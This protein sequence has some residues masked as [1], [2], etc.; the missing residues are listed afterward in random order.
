MNPIAEEADLLLEALQ[1]ALTTSPPAGVSSAYM[2]GFFRRHRPRLLT[3]MARVLD[4]DD[5]EA[6]PAKP[7]QPNAPPDLWT[8]AQRTNANLRAMEILARKTPDQITAQDRAAL[9]LY[10]GWGGLSIEKVKARFPEGSETPEQ[11][12]L[13][14]EYYTPTAV[15]A[16]VARVVQPLLRGLQSRAGRVLALEP[17]AGIGRFVRA[18]SGPGFESVDWLTVEW[19]AL[20]ARML[21]TLR[22]DLD[23][24]QGPFERWVRERGA[25]VN[26]RLKLVIS[27]PPY[28]ARGASISEDP[29]RDYREK[30]AYAYFLRR[31]LDL[32]APRGLGVFLVPSGFLSG[33]AARNEKLRA[34]VLRRHHL[35]AAFRLPSELF[36]GVNLVTDLIFFRA[37][38]VSMDE[39]PAEDRYI[40]EGDYFNRHPANILGREVGK[41][42]GEDQPS[43]FYRYTIEGKFSKL[44][45]LVERPICAAC[46]ID[47][48]P[49]AEDE[50]P[51]PFLT[52]AGVLRQVRD[53]ADG[54]SD[55][56][57]L[58]VALGLRVDRY[59]T[60]LAT[61]SPEEAA[62]LWGELHHALTS[63][64][65]RYG[66]PW[67]DAV[68]VG[69]ARPPRSLTGAERFLAAF[70]KLGELIPGLQQR[71]AVTRRYNGRRDDVLA[72]AEWLFKSRRALTL[73]ELEAAWREHNS[74]PFS[75]R[76]A[77]DALI[78]GGWFWDRD[79]KTGAGPLLPRDHYL[80]GHLWPRYD[81]ATAI[82]SQADAIATVHA[83][84]LLTAIRPATYEEIDGL[85]PRQGWIPLDIVEAWI[86]ARLQKKH[87][88]LPAITLE[89]VNGLVSLVDREYSDLDN[90]R[91]V[92]PETLSCIGWMNHDRTLFKPKK[93]KQ[94]DDIDEVRLKAA[95][96]WESDFRVWLG[97][98]EP[99]R[100]RI[101]EVYNRLFRGYVAPTYASEPLPIARWAPKGPRLHPHQVAGARRILANKGGMVAFDVGVG[102]TYTGIAVLAHA[103]QE[104]WVRRP[105]VLV[106]NS[107][108]WKWEA[109]IRRVLPDYRVAVIGSKRKVIS[110]GPRKGLLTSETDTPEER[111]SKW[112]RFQAGEYD[113]VLLAYTSLGRTRMNEGVLR[114]YAER[115]EAIQ[116][117][118][119][120]R[121]RNAE[122]KE[123]L[124]EREEAILKE[125][126]A[127]WIAEKMELP[128]KWEYDPGIAWDDIGIDLLIVD[129]AQN[130]KEL[131]AVG[132]GAGTGVPTS[133]QGPS[134]LASRGPRGRRRAWG[135]PCQGSGWS[136]RSRRA[137]P[138]RARPAR[139]VSR[140]ESSSPAYPQSPPRP[141]RAAARAAPRRTACPAWVPA[142]PPGPRWPSAGRPGRSPSAVPARAGPGAA[143]AAR[144]G[145]RAQP[146]VR[147]SPPR[148]RAPWSWR[149]APALATRRAP[150]AA[151]PP[152]S[153]PPRRSA[154]SSAPRSAPARSRRAATPAV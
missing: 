127:A 139:A 93:Q 58:A 66:S 5:G 86:N 97:G 14:H 76:A 18:L 51:S 152:P 110:R 42:E 37:R 79:P 15:A 154:A 91:G 32:L 75:S 26:G 134:A 101:E 84:E 20:S 151:P 137:P 45:P 119:A 1:G 48:D 87:G 71:P 68:L 63:W 83:R 99:L 125:G 112:T 82:A 131:V 55:K 121:Q 133:S 3:L 56:H 85:S 41:D 123:D 149:A 7:T 89:R 36:P 44:P 50:A 116:R 106:P 113:V 107:I 35:S 136:S 100:V 141:D 25:K 19:S 129:E 53:E 78:K 128:K 46:A 81:R 108:I 95:E 24:F 30:A 117:E 132:K 10:S 29:D 59:L 39:L 72:L 31:G 94:S 140:P 57:A 73:A 22:P 143:A 62:Q 21:Q 12:G 103:R 124:S 147:R 49:D 69:L 2:S 105:V 9:A 138:P 118:I 96:A 126:T 6:P 67:M 43:K 70:T 77:V 150:R 27:N 28:G 120:L 40:I 145:Y 33:R 11:R 64:R 16:E 65:A 111:A 4:A 61:E 115:T 34:T 38:G 146:P 52:S 88:S 104:G 122:G 13:I 74:A 148:S 102:K 8:A 135:G 114:A 90:V 92:S 130:Y 47:A 60:Q 109:D 54:L 23:M 142:P 17:S 80:T 98:D 144:A 153:L